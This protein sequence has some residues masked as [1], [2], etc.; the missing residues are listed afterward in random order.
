MWAGV[1]KL[2]Y[3]PTPKLWRAGARDFFAEGEL[4]ISRLTDRV[5]SI[6]AVAELVDA[7]DLK[8]RSG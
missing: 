1:A 2:V 3:P 6:A 4:A 7:R 5:K 8:S